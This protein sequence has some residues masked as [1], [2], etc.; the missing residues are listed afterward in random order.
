MGIAGHIHRDRQHI[1]LDQA[2]GRVNDDVVTNAR[3]F[4]VEAAQDAQRP[5]VLELQLGAVPLTAVIQ[6]EPCPPTHS[7][8]LPRCAQPVVCFSIQLNNSYM[9]MAITPTTSKPLKAKPICMELPAEIN[10]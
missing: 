3:A 7:E 10:K 5:L 6:V 1:A 2:P 9:A 4:W 8:W